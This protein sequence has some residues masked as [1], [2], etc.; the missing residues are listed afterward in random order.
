MNDGR[1]RGVETLGSGSGSMEG[2]GLRGRGKGHGV[3][4]SGVQAER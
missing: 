1:K 3:L 4:C 2:R